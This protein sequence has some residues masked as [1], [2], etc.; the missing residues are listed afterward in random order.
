MNKQEA[1][2]LFATGFFGSADPELLKVLDTICR[3]RTVEKKSILFVEGQEG[4]TVY[5][6]VKGSIKLFR[7]NDEGREAVVHF[8]RSGEIFA[9][10]LLQLGLKYPVTSMTLEECDLLEMDAMKLEEVISKD[11]KVS[12]RLIG[13]LAK[14]IKYF[15]NLIESL[16]VNDVRARLVN[17][18]RNQKKKESAVVR[19]PVPKGELAL[20]LGTTAE[21]FSRVLKKLQEEG[22]IE[23]QGRDI[24]ILKN[25]D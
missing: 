19:L 4:S 3:H 14:R 2:K 6:L 24:K 12:M 15:V 22:Y 17:W 11:P 5:F 23:V 18:L 13:A 10:I 16:T 20:L 21:T 1:V 7:T 8:V 9:E 25:L